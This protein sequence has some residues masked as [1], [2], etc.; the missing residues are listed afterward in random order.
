MTKRRIE[1]SFDDVPSVDDLIGQLS[2]SNTRNQNTKFSFN[3]TIKRQ[4]NE[5]YRSIRFDQNFR[6][7]KNDSSL[8]NAQLY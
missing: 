7:V 4:S 1:Q 6:D 3:Q 2:K 8:E 5:K